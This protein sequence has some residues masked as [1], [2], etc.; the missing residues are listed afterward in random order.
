[1]ILFSCK[2]V[3]TFAVIAVSEIAVTVP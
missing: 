1:V 3:L 2:A